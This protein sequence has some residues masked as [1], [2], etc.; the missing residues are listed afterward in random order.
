MAVLSR[1]LIEKL[2]E[3]QVLKIEPFYK[4]GIQ[5]ASYDL[6]LGN[7]ILVTPIK[8]GERGRPIDLDKE[9][10]EKYMIRPGEF[11]AALT[12][13]SLSLPDDICG[14]FG[15]KSSLA[16]KG[17]VAFGGI[18]I[19]PGFVGRL[20]ISL[21]NVGP[22]DIELKLGEPTFTV[23]FHR[24]EEPT[25]NPYGSDPQK[26]T[27]QGQTDFPA[28]QRNFIINAHTT[29]LAEIPVIR[30]DMEQI[31][32]RVNIL[33]ILRGGTIVDFFATKVSQ[34]PEVKRVLIT[35]EQGAI[36]VFT[37]F[38][39]PDVNVEYGIYDIEQEALLSFEEAELDFHAI[40]LA[41]YE[42]EAWPYLI[43]SGAKEVF[44]RDE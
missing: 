37:I 3:A 18:Q 2:V 40:N 38:D 23:E 5:P 6:R 22:E 24:L 28:D 14:R 34:M 11:V 43:P 29:S 20:A 8:R 26:H 27:Y 36:D 17:L 12:E 30:T 42:Q 39:S 35:Q 21:F 4:D 1:E 31:G 7:T 41:D 13:E 10:G 19:D 25:K 33:E 32:R 16:R 9:K 44:G 15:V